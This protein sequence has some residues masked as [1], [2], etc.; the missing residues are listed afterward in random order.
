MKIQR[1]WNKITY[2][3]TPLPEIVYFTTKNKNVLT[4]KNKLHESFFLL[5]I[6]YPLMFVW[7][8][9]NTSI[10]GTRWL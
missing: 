1:M 5:Y 10:H 7:V 8:C 2:I 9:Q 4:A 6:S 3:L